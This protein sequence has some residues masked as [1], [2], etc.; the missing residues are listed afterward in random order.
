MKRQVAR[1]PKQ[2]P[3]V[4]FR[5]AAS[6]VFSFLVTELGFSAPDTAADGREISFVFKRANVA[7]VLHYELGGEPSVGVSILPKGDRGR[8]FGLPVIVAEHLG[9]PD[10][11]AV[12]P[13]WSSLRPCLAELAD[14]LKTHA[15][16]ILAGHQ[17]RLPGLRRLQAQRKRQDNQERHG[18]ATGETPRFSRRPSLPQLFS[19]TLGNPGLLEP[20]A[21]QA[22][23]D[24]G[25]SVA[26]LA[27]F[28]KRSN[29]DVAGLLSAWEDMTS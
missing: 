19:D 11:R 13:R 24:Y 14:L 26:E 5:H 18:T 22:V 4:E 8:H 7:V 21:Y 15:I 2:D 16:D 10:P 9:I 6:S 1:T 12:L 20:R 28:L 25:Y 3:F 27:D 17:D 29:D 23:W